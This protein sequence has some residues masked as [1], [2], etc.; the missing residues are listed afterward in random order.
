M[1]QALVSH[2]KKRFSFTSP[3]L[4][5]RWSITDR[6]CKIIL[7]FL[8]WT[9]KRTVRENRFS[10][11]GLLRAPHAKIPSLMHFSLSTTSKTSILSSPPTHIILISSLSLIPRL[12]WVAVGSAQTMSAGRPGTAAGSGSAT[13]FA[14]GGRGQRHQRAAAERPHARSPARSG[15]PRPP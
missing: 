8:R 10:H 9:L 2:Y 3:L 7:L 4:D 6:V 5:F 13:S 15:A 14:G 1:T 12:S 11:V